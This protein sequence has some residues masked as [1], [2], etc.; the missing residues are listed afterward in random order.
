MSVFFVPAPFAWLSV[1][2]AWSTMPETVGQR[3]LAKPC[4]TLRSPIHRIIPPGTAMNSTPKMAAM[5]MTYFMMRPSTFSNLRC[6]KFQETPI[7][8]FL[9]SQSHEEVIKLTLQLITIW[10]SI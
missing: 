5:P 7:M 2:P 9:A 3:E 8:K 1:I 10:E 4:Q 6:A